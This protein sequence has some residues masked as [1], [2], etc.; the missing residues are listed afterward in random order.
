MFINPK[1]LHVYRKYIRR[2]YST[3]AES[4][5]QRNPFFYKHL[6]PWTSDIIFK[7]RLKRR[8]YFYKNEFVKAELRWKL[9]FWKI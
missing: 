8:C 1:G 5:Q 6:M 3:P 9:K 7:H 4:N 2:K